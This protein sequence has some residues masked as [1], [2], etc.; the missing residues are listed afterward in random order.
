MCRKINSEG[1]VAHPA[2]AI[3][4]GC[5]SPSRAG[6]QQRF[7]RWR[8]SF[9][10]RSG[11][12]NLFALVGALATILAPFMVTA[13]WANDTTAELTTGGLVFA[14]SSKLVMRAEDL[15][16][17]SK[18]IRVR[19]RF[20]NAASRDVTSVIAFPMPDL[21]FDGPDSNLA[22][23]S[24]AP[25]NFLDF[26]TA[27]DGR[28]VAANLEQ[29]AIAKGVDQ[30]KRLKELGVPL[31]PQLEQTKKSLDALTPAQKAEF[32]KLKL[33]TI[34]DY[35][36]GKGMEHHLSPAWTLKSTY[37]W[38]QTFPARREIIVEHRYRPSVGETT[39]TQLG[40]TDLEKNS[41]AEYETT[42]CVDRDFLDAA[43][44][45]MG[46]PDQFGAASSPFFERRIA[47]VLTT[48]ANWA[49]PI[50]DFH[51][52]IDKGA[53]DSLVSFCG[54]DVKKIGATQYEMHRTNFTPSRELHILLLYRPKL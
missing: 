49:A 54:E 9:L 45:A 35:D 48:G 14:K 20:F 53:T 32:V 8:T 3:Q 52:V 17:S 2:I 7:R 47:Y 38:R 11:T 39:G 19:Y 34:N 4:D 21:F 27:V 18:E 37:F 26:Q 50:G 28:P 12:N 1:I 33:A 23:P 5:D 15:F 42:Y 16:V 22:I 41:L 44:R 10:E 25:E 36:V 46:K 40:S 30:T 29:K 31:G 13:V 43:R 51:L 24:E 6:E